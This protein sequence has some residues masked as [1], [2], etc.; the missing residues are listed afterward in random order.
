VEYKKL[1][2]VG[3]DIYPEDFTVIEDFRTKKKTFEETG[4]KVFV[5]HMNGIN[6]FECL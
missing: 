5:F 2:I 4:K 1:Y 6:E 3:G